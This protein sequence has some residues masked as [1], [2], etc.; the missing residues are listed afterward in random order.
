MYVHR[1]GDVF[2]PIPSGSWARFDGVDFG[3]GGD[4][5]TVK[6]YAK[7]FNDGATVSFYV[8]SPAVTDGGVLVASVK[9]VPP[10]P[11][12]TARPGMLTGP[13]QTLPGFSYFNGTTGAG[14]STPAGIH[15]VFMV[16]EAAKR[17]PRTGNAAAPPPPPVHGIGA[18][19][20][21]FSFLRS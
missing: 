13:Q 2:A 15:S 8:N 21:W 3:R 11:P 7:S 17:P 19:V 4:H 6:V 9:I 12:L 14:A 10:P 1:T 5:L 18:N 20:D 16:F